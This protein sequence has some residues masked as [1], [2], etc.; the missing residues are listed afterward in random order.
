MPGHELPVPRKTQK[1][2]VDQVRS[3]TEVLVPAYT[4]LLAIEKDRET[5]TL[6]YLFPNVS[7]DSAINLGNGYNRGSASRNPSSPYFHLVLLRRLVIGPDLLK[8]ASR[9]HLGQH[10]ESILHCVWIVEKMT[11]NGPQG[12][13]AIHRQ[14]HLSQTRGCR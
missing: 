8:N 1:G 6:L 7:G 5:F 11:A 3:N 4:S 10:G 9:D 13:V 12:S 14:E 2:R